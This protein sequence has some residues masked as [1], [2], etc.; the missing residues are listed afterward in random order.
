MSSSA[1]AQ[2]AE[3]RGADPAKYRSILDAAER[4]F[5]RYG[6][7]KTTID[8]VAGEAGVGKG[9]IYS[10]FRSKEELLLAYSDRCSDE[11][12]EAAGQAAA[13]PGHFVDRLTA[14]MR[15]I[16]L[17]IWDRVHAGPHGEEV[18]NALL[19][20]IIDRHCQAICREQEMI[21]A[22]LVDAQQVGALRCED[23]EV[24]ARLIWR[25][26]KSFGPPYGPLTGSRDEIE[27]GIAEMA[28]LIFYGLR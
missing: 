3:D 21:A 10:Y 23:P 12:F 25:A 16:L 14:L 7:K 13:T 1:L 19:P 18:F 17:G 15:S 24:T 2:Q 4:L 26:F 11:I 27:A 22:L 5:V 8:E 9:T 28:K 6:Y 20:K